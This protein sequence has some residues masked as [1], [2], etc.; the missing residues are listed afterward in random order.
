MTYLVQISP[1]TVRKKCVAIQA[2]HSRARLRFD[3]ARGQD[4]AVG[5]QVVDEPNLQ[6]FARLHP[7]ASA[8]AR[9]RKRAGKGAWAHPRATATRTFPEVAFG[10]LSDSCTTAKFGSLCGAFDAHLDFAVESLEVDWYGQ[11]P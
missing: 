8:P 10:P 5:G 2:A 3:Y 6:G 9:L 1:G 7:A 4:I 11:Q